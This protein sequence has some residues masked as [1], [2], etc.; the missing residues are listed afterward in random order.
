MSR[1]EEL[2]N[3]TSSV[4]MKNSLSWGFLLVTFGEFQILIELGIYLE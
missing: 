3:Q 4:T 1:E 2:E